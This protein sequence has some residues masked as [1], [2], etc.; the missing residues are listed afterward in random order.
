MRL[1]LAFSSCNWRIERD[2]VLAC[3]VAR[4]LFFTDPLRLPAVGDTA[5]AWDLYARR[6]WRPGKPHR[7]TWD[8]FHAQA[9]EQV[10]GVHA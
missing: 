3:G 7:Q 1:R 5:S 6:T 10:A 4:L 8:A 2:D 9:R